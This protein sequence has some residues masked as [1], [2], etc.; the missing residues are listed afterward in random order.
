MSRTAILF[1]LDGTLVDTAPDLHAALNVALAAL[2]RP[3]VT[4]A[5]VR[6]MIGDGAQRMVELGLAATGGSTASELQTGVAHC[7]G[8]YE[9]NISRLSRP[10]PGVVEALAELRLRGCRLAV[11][12]NKRARFSERLLDDLGLLASFDAV[13]G[14]DSLPVRKPDPGHILGT[15]GKLGAK[16]AQAVMVGDSANDVN[17]ARAAAVPVIVVSFGYTAVPPRELGADAL[18]D[19]FDELPA[20]LARFG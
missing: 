8:H 3:G 17:A 18:I 15:L 11:C 16:P 1:D 4:S 20:A 7:L 6:N 10:F 12:T 13:V 9:A 5:S 2:G 14:G 19:H